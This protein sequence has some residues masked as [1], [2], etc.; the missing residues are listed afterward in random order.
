MKVSEFMEMLNRLEEVHGDVEVMINTGEVKH[1][2]ETAE[3]HYVN[4]LGFVEV[5]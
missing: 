2:W 3:P 1:E 5:Y 4:H